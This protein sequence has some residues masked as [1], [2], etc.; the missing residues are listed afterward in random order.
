MFE[1]EA[2]LLPYMETVF[3]FFLLT[4][5]DDDVQKP[6]VKFSTFIS[7]NVLLDIDIAKWSVFRRC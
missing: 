7:L 5:A 6:R 2:V 3:E 4:R 1:T